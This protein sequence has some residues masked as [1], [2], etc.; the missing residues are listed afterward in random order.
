MAQRN[1]NDMRELVEVARELRSALAE[2]AAAANAA[3][4]LP[5]ETI[6]DLQ[7]LG[8]LHLLQSKRFGGLEGP[9]ATFAEIAEI[10]SICAS[11]RRCRPPSRWRGTRSISSPAR[12][13]TG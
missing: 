6:A 5:P 8:I 10:L 2:R 13:R 12:C 9:F 3:G 4:M 1:W 7:R 11:I